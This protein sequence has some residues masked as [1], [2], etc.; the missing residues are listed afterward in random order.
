[1]FLSFIEKVRRL[2]GSYG[3]KLSAAVHACAIIAVCAN[4][5]NRPVKFV[6]DMKSNMETYGKRCP[7]LIK[8]K[9]RHPVLC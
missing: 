2:G 4:K 5:L 7:Y 6:M 1:M 8:W 3:G 9:V